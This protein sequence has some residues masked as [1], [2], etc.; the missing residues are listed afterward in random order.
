MPSGNEPNVSST[1]SP[2]TR[3]LYQELHQL[4]QQVRRLQSPSLQPQL[5]RVPG[6]QYPVTPLP[7]P[8]SQPRTLRAWMSTLGT[9]L[10]RRRHGTG[11]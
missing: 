11:S 4:Q 9:L 5:P 6:H 10:R 3:D 8:E 7:Q 1:C 2:S